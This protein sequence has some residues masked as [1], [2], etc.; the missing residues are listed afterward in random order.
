M[1]LQTL[2]REQRGSGRRQPD[3]R[4]HRSVWDRTLAAG[5]DGGTQEQDVP[6]Q[7]G[8]EGMDPSYL[9]PDNVPKQILFPVQTPS[10]VLVSRGFPLKPVP[11]ESRDYPHHA[12]IFFAYD[13]VNGNNFWLNIGKSPHIRQV[14]ILTS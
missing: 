8:T 4:G 2:P 3:V 5:I 6:G 14:K 10:G 12:G 11:G 1:G 9:Y 13:Q 7:S